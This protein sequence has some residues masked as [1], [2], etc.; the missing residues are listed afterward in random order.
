M[1]SGV[2]VVLFQFAHQLEEIV[3]FVTVVAVESQ[4]EVEVVAVEVVVV[5]R[6]E[7]V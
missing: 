5:D 1:R 6:I 4:A 3:E 2:F 7:Q